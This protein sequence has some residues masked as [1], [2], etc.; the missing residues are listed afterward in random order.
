MLFHHVIRDADGGARMFPD[1][2]TSF[3]GGSRE[4]PDGIDA[5]ATPT[6]A[7]VD[8]RTAR[9][10]RARPRDASIDLAPQGRNAES[11]L[12]MRA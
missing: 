3:L 5:L 9:S 6:I 10:L 11:A 1:W 8:A 7:P 12:A 4:E 2:T